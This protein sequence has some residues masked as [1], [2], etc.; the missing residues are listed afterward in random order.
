MSSSPRS[1]SSSKYHEVNE[2]EVSRIIGVLTMSYF[3]SSIEKSHNHKISFEILSSFDNNRQEK[4]VLYAQSIISP[5]ALNYCKNIEYLF[6]E[7][8]S[9]SYVECVQDFDFLF[10]LLR[11]G[12]M[13]GIVPSTPWG[14]WKTPSTWS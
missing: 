11:P 14:G 5:L 10:V 8:P 4:T 9:F 2:K 3:L 1:Y 12:S 7:G 13:H 6:M